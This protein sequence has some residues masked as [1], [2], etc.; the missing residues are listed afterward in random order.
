MAKLTL[1]RWL[2]SFVRNKPKTFQ[3]LK[4]RQHLRMEEL[5]DRVTPATLVW[6]GS[7]N[8]GWDN[9]QNWNNSA[10]NTLIPQDG[11]DLVF[12]GGAQRLA[13]SNNIDDLLLNSITFSGSG[14]SLT[15]TPL[16]IGTG[17]TGPG[18]GFIFANLGS[19]NNSIA[20][21]IT[22]GGSAGSRQ[23]FTVGTLGAFL[24][25]SGKLSGST[26]VEL[27]HRDGRR[28]KADPR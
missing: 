20:F 2:H 3:K 12:P 17:A 24:T 1:P 7:A 26:G 21:D 13:N 22:L 14:Y 18:S 8:A 6:D 16:T 10:T 19:I 25:I 9:P 15:G 11:D 23:F 5:E 27:W 28:T 4:P